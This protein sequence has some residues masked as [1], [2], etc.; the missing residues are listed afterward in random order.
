MIHRLN[1]EKLMEGNLV[2]HSLFICF[3]KGSI[4]GLFS[5]NQLYTV[6]NYHAYLPDERNQDQGFINDILKKILKHSNNLRVLII[7]CHGFQTY[8]NE[9]KII[10]TTLHVSDLYCWFLFLLLIQKISWL[11]TDLVVSSHSNFE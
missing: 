4:C 9:S 2:I 8:Y 11:Y 6:K 3:S 10:I 1:R 7:V 5:F